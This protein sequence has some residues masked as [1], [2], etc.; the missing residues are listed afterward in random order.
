MLSNMQGF[1]HKKW[2]GL[3]SEDEY[4]AQVLAFP[5]GELNCLVRGD[6][7]FHHCIACAVNSI[8]PLKHIHWD[9]L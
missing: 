3:V 2:K 4:V 7:C 8:A 5:D 6:N 9:F 1:L